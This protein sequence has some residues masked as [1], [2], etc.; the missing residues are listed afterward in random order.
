MSEINKQNTELETIINSLGTIKEIVGNEWL[1]LEIL[2]DYDGRT[3]SIKFYEMLNEAI[4]AGEVV[5]EDLT[6]LRNGQFANYLLNLESVLDALGKRTKSY[7]RLMRI[8]DTIQINDVETL[9]SVFGN[10]EMIKVFAGINFDRELFF[11]RGYLNNLPI[12]VR[13]NIAKEVIKA[14]NLEEGMRML[15]EIEETLKKE[16]DYEVNSRV[17]L[18]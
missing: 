13:L 15:E 5:E 7:D 18:G 17:R 2:T 16:R 6:I 4:K 9:K 10:E 12:E 11:C 8:I 1:F 14:G 3:L